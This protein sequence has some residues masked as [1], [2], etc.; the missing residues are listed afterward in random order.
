MTE[1]TGPVRVRF[2]PSPTGRPHV[3]GIRTAMFNWLM[4]RH[5]GGKFILSIDDT[6][7]AR[8]V[9]GA[10]EYIGEGLKWLGLNWDEGPDIGGDYGPY[11]QSE[12]LNLYQQAA[13]RLVKQ[14]HA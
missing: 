3:G 6:D 4:A 10:G 1:S 2:A 5:Y 11:T 12:R 7:V 8:Q 14:G 9:E 13:E